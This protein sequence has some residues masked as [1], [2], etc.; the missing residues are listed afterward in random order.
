MI[1]LQEESETSTVD[2]LQLGNSEYNSKG[3]SVSEWE[4]Y[5]QACYSSFGF[6][7]FQILWKYNIIFFYL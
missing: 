5:S 2:S 1:N 3:F 7:I 4:S 6:Y